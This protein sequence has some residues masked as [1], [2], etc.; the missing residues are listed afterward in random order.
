VSAIDTAAKTYLAAIGASAI[1][2]CVEGGK[3][4]SVGVARDLDKALRHLHSIFSPAASFGWVAW[5]VDYGALVQLAQAVKPTPPLYEL[6][7]TIAEEARARGIV[8][9]PHGRA[10]ERSKVYAGYLDQAIAT[11]Q[12]EGTLAAF[13]LAYK[14]HRLALHRRGQSAQP[15]WAVMQELRTLIIRSLVASPKNRLDAGAVITQIRQQFPWFVRPT[16]LPKRKKRK[17]RN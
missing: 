1:Y 11:M 15:Y 3:P 6:V 5:G 14:S 2:V 17:H 7:A 16:L 10:L 12:A 9:T 13:N 8:L 4:I